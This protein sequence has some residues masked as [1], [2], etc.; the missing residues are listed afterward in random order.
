MNPKYVQAGAEP[1]FVIWETGWEEI[2]DQNLPGIFKEEIFKRLGRRVTQFVRGKLDKTLGDGQSK[3]ISDLPLKREDQIRDSIEAERSGKSGLFSDLALDQ[4]PSEMALS[5]DETN[6]IEEAIKNDSQLEEQLQEIANTRQPSPAA[7]SR[8]I[9]AQA[10]TH[11]YMDPEVLDEIVPVKEGAKG[12]ISMAMLAKH[13]V[14][15]VAAVIARFVK[16]RDHG[17]YLTIMEE[18][19]REFYVRNAGKFLWDG[20]KEE[21]NEAFGF[22]DSYGGT[23]LVKYLNEM[24]SAGLKPRVTLVGHSAG[25]IYISRLLK[26]LDKLPPDF[27]A[28]VIFVAPACTFVALADAV[29]V[30]GKRIDGMRVFGMGNAIELKD[31]IVGPLYPASLLY[32]VSGV[33]E[34]ERDMPLVGMERYYK[35]PYVGAGFDALAFVEA[36]DY[37]KRKN[38]FCWSQVSGDNGTNCDMTSHGG[39]TKADAT[40]ESVLYIVREGYGYS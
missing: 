25:S 27:K 22:G 11:T 30:A 6:Q 21:V 39:W 34:D 9:T 2:V 4:I 32:F 35:A 24:W 26:E 10:S 12:F 18:V 23:L 29:K 20:M 31:A 13:V 15:I 14:V 40:R 16:Y 5:K 36:F 1:L 28:D 19:M 7:A 38:A 33:I 3:A 37:L 8:G 17:P